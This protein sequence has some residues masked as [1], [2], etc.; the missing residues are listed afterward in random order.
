[1]IDK[2]LSPLRNWGLLKQSTRTSSPQRAKDRSSRCTHGL[3]RHPSS[4]RTFHPGGHRVKED[5]LVFRSEAWG[6]N[7]G[8]G[9]S[10]LLKCLQGQDW[11][12]VISQVASVSIVTIALGTSRIT[13][14]TWPLSTGVLGTGLQCMKRKMGSCNTA[15]V[16]KKPLEESICRF[17]PAGRG[18]A[19]RGCLKGVPRDH[20]PLTQHAL[21]F[22]W[23]NKHLI[24]YFH[25][26]KLEVLRATGAIP[27]SHWNLIDWGEQ[28]AVQWM[29]S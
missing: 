14:I 10:G 15:I 2:D 6:I 4:L 16:F 11:H 18:L 29:Q 8:W 13:H 22:K 20:F 17:T 25:A 5:S 1:M 28:D 12:R 23:T 27:D 9:S 24:I 7:S 19:T 3:N 21:D 26:K